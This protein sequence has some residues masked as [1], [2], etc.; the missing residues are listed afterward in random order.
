MNSFLDIIKRTTQ[1]NDKMLDEKKIPIVERPRT[2]PAMAIPQAFLRNAIIPP[3]H[4]IAEKIRKITP[5][6]LM[7]DSNCSAVN[8]ASAGITF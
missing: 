1:I 3:T 4:I 6:I 8:G 2:L 7:Y 5:H